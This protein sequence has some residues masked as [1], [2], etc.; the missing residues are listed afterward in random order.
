[1]HKNI[2]NASGESWL[3][4]EGNIIHVFDNKN[5]AICFSYLLEKIRNEPAGVY[6]R[7]ADG[8]LQNLLFY[9]DKDTMQEMVDMYLTLQ[10]EQILATANDRRGEED[11]ND[12]D[13]N[14]E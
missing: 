4:M 7:Y 14:Q 8:K 11:F 13:D 3:V 2:F 12:D 10:G 5:E 1:M 6:H 9:P